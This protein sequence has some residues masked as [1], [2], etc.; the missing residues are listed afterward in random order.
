MLRM[1]TDTRWAASRQVF[2]RSGYCKS[3]FNYFF[4]SFKVKLASKYVLMCLT[5]RSIINADIIIC[6]ALSAAVQFGRQK[7]VLK[8]LQ[9]GADK[10]IKTNAGKSPADLAVILK[11][12]QAHGVLL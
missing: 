8:L 9:L 6:Q 3:E 11:K 5:L 10:T 7:A 1:P 12:T 4:C 2:C